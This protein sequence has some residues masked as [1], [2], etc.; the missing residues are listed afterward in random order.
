MISDQLKSMSLEQ[1][2]GQLFMCGFD[3][4]RP[5]EP[6]LRLIC[7]YHIGGVNYFRRN[8]RTTGQVA[9]LSAGLQQASAIPLLVSIDQEGGMVAGIEEGVTLMPG[10]MALGAT[11][12]IEA[13]CKAALIAG[14][15]LRALGINMDFAPCLDINNNPDNPVIGVR[16]Y[17]ESPNLV[18]DMGSAA[19]KGYREAGVIAT[20]KHFPGHG[21]TEADSHH[22]LPLVAHD[23]RRLHE[24]ELVPFKQ[25]IA[26]GVDSVMTAHVIFPAYEPRNVPA[27]L[28]RNILTGLLREELGFDG[29]ITTDCLEMNAISQGVGVGQGAVMAVEAGADLVLISH[30]ISLQVEGIEAVLE[31]VRQGRISEARIDESVER[32]LRLKEKYGLFTQTLE[33]ADTIL[34]RIGTEA[35]MDFA[36]NLS[37]RSITLVRNEGQVPLKRELSTYIVWPDMRPVSET[38]EPAGQ[39]TTLGRL[40][41]SRIAEC[42]EQ[43]IHVEPGEAEIR[44]VLLDSLGYTQI[45]VATYNAGFSAGQQRIVKELAR[46]EGIHLTV[47]SL[48]NPYDIN[49]FPEVT[50]Y[51]A[52]YENKPLAIRSL[53]N[54]LMGELPARGALPV[55]VIS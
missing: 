17:G 16:S 4:T 34:S 9:A 41:L 53:T 7:E 29:V 40:L 11:R 52:C 14:T 54:V 49:S 45:V 43:I 24:V 12:D 26:S 47:V 46:R 30:Q 8:V 6:I 19:V 22:E 23:R 1:K 44:Q 10:N 2:V 13:V 28:S 55:S 51:L 35:T 27:T 36:R 5:N 15:E 18:A 38:A 33:D 37:E 39:E 20:V 21:D 48:R 42:K 31:A 25:A 50:S 32:L 3:D